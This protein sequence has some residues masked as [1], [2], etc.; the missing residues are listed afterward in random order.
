MNFANCGGKP[1]QRTCM[2][3]GIQSRS[4]YIRSSTRDWGLLT[5]QIDNKRTLGA[6][7]HQVNLQADEGCYTCFSRDRMH[8]KT[9]AHI[10]IFISLIFACFSSLVFAFTSSHGRLSHVEQL[11]F[12]QEFNT[13]S[14]LTTSVYLLNGKL[15]IMW[16]GKNGRFCYQYKKPHRCLLTCHWASTRERIQ[17]TLSHLSCSA[18]FKTGHET[19]LEQ[20]SLELDYAWVMM[21]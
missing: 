3:N 17:E 15:H 6:E 4:E 16:I 13:N 10:S 12:R 21:V 11:H 18:L 14:N 19:F 20:P 2:C 7:R 5:R 9:S 1:S 8:V